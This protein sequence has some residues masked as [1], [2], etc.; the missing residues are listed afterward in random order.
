[1]TT[2]MDRVLQ[3]ATVLRDN[4]GF[5]S[6]PD[7][8]ALKKIRKELALSQSN[9][10]RAFGL[11]VR[12]VQNWEQGRTTPDLAAANYLWLIIED[13]RMVLHRINQARMKQKI[14]VYDTSEN[15]TTDYCQERNKPIKTP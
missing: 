7:G 9:F 14:E 1:M 15:A 4:K 5:L 3:A 8:M 2:K 12:T 13:P 6:A 10:A 11:D